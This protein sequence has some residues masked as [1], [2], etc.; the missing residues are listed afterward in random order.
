ML[1]DLDFESFEHAGT[2]SRVV[3]VQSLPR[4]AATPIT[5]PSVADPVWRN[6]PGFLSSQHLSASDP[7]QAQHGL[8]QIS[9]LLITS[10]EKC[11]AEAESNSCKVSSM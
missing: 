2:A 8:V 3:S 4:L 1:S 7:L 6:T 5:D 11:V 10:T 9:Q